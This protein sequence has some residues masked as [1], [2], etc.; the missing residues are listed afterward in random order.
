MTATSPVE[1]SAEEDQAASQVLSGFGLDVSHPLEPG[2]IVRIGCSCRPGGG[3]A[4][5]YVYHPSPLP[6]LAYGCHRCHPE[7]LRW[8]GSRGREL[9]AEEI[10]EMRAQGDRD[11]AAKELA[12]LTVASEV[13][14]VMAHLPAGDPGHPYLTRKRISLPPGVKAAS[15]YGKPTLVVPLVDVNGKVWSNQQITPEKIQC[16]KSGARDKFF[17]TGGRTRG[18]FFPLG[19]WRGAERI[20]VCEGFST[21]AT[22]HEAAGLPTVCAMSSGNLLAVAKD[23]RRA[24][25]EA[26][27]V[28]AADNDRHT[29]DNPGMRKAKEAARAVGGVIAVPTFADN[30]EGTDFNDMALNLGTD[31]VSTLFD[32]LANSENT[33]ETL[34]RLYGEPF[35]TTKPKE[36]EGE[37]IV[38]SLNERFWAGA[39]ARENRILFDPADQCFY[40]YQTET[41]LWLPMTADAIR[42]AI[43]ARVLEAGREAGLDVTPVI[44]TRNLES[45]VK[46]LRGITERGD[47][48]KKRP[49]V[50]HVANGVIQLADGEGFEFREFSPEDYSRNRSPISFDCKSDFDP[51][52]ACPRFLNE[53]L[54]PAM[55]EE[56]VE[57]LQRYVGLSLL[58]RNLP[59]R[60]LILEGTPGG[61]KGTLVRVIQAIV[62]LANSYQL[63]TEHLSERFEIFRYRD[64]T[65]L[66]GADVPGNFLMQKGAST[67]KALVGGDLLSGEGKGSN[68]N[69][70]ILGEFCV[71]I[72]ANSRL[73]VRLEED[74]GAW[75]RRLLLIRYDRPPVSKKIPTLTAF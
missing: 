1:V 48:F 42:E 68:A 65:L 40:R 4:G 27:M 54:R 7:T 18:C 24:N 47:A 43:S 9:S 41:G 32:G 45:I 36:K 73:K 13:E 31:A 57:M 2:R 19:E 67:L 52:S 29:T 51:N 30:E 62:G 60:I 6:R 61:G 23:I 33:M 39:F 74:S 5:W 15:S 17:E 25:P 55:N 11:R 20:V 66:F 14:R 49:M 34:L 59:Q 58:G 72:A 35:V 38:K 22:I 64:K 16:G 12:Q 75:R 28:I 46:A 71:I 69:C 37:P 44:K 70:M 63:R 26:A 3:A 50:I 10:A 8:T 53:L 56:D 21:G